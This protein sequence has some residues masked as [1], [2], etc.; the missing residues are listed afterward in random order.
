MFEKK[1]S[2][3]KLESFGERSATLNG[4]AHGIDSLAYLAGVKVAGGRVLTDRLGLDRGLIHQSVDLYL[5]KFALPYIDRL[6]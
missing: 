1:V 3:T 4:T 5:L 2:L 6:L